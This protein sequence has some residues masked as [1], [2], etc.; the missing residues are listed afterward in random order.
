MPAYGNW[1]LSVS[2]ASSRAGRVSAIAGIVGT[3]AAE[4]SSLPCGSLRES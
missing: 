2:D 3:H 4:P 1:T